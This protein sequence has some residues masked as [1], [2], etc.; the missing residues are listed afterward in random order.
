MVLLVS[1]IKTDLQRPVFFWG[2]YTLKNG[3][4][5]EYKIIDLQNKIKYNNAYAYIYSL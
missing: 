1:K 4:N 2:G 3:H 5:N